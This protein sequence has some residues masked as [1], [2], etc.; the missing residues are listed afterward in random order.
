MLAL[1]RRPYLAE[2]LA[3]LDKRPRTLA[4]LRAATGAPHRYAVAALRALA[5][6]RAVTRTPATGTWDAT[7]DR[8]IRYRLT[9]AGHALIDDLFHIEVWQAAYQSDQPA[10]PDRA[11]RHGAARDSAARDSAARRRSATA[12]A[13]D[14]HNE[15]R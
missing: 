15:E 12:P 7:G 9:P 14:D 11:P 5:A 6:H 1:I 3:A 10:T 13:R 2:V 4:G 8:R